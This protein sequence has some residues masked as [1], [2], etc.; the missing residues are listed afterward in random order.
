MCIKVPGVKNSPMT[1]DRKVMLLT[2]AV[3]VATTTV[4]IVGSILTATTSVTAWIQAQSGH[5]VRDVAIVLVLLTAAIVYATVMLG[6]TQEQ[7]AAS[8]ANQPLGDD[9][10]KKL[11]ARVL[12]DRVTPRLQQGLRKA[13]RIGNHL[14]IVPSAVLPKLRIYAEAESGPQL[15]QPTSDPIA[16]I[17]EQTASGRLL[18]LGDP[19]TGKTNLLLELAGD[20]IH[21]AEADP[22][23]P[24]PIIF[25]LPRW[26]LGKSVRKLEEWLVDDLISEYGISR[27]T[28]SSLVSGNRLITL[29]DGLDEVAEH[30]RDACVEA[31][32]TFQREHD[33]AQ[34]VVCCRIKEY[35]QMPSLELEAAVRIERLTRATIEAELQK[36]NMETVAL[37]LH[38]DP[39]LW[40]IIDTPLWI[41][42]LFGAAQL[43]RPIQDEVGD[44]RERLYARYIEYALSR[45]PDGYP[46]KLTDREHMLRWLGWLATAMQVRNQSQFSFEDL[47]SGWIRFEASSRWQRLLQILVYLCAFELTFGV[48]YLALWKATAIASASLWIPILAGLGV[49][50]GSI[51]TSGRRPTEGISFVWTVTWQS[52]TLNL[53]LAVF[54][55]V[56]AWY[57]FHSWRP[58]VVLFIGILITT[59]LFDCVRTKQL[60]ERSDPNSGTV[61]SFRVALSLALGSAAF[62]AIHQLLAHTNN[63]FVFT[64][65]MAVFVTAQFLAIIAFYWA[66]D[67]VI[68]N[69]T[70]RVLL[71][72]GRRLPLRAIR[73][74]NEAVA[75]LLLIQRG[76]SYEFVHPTFRDHF[77][78]MYG[79]QI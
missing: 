8:A 74:F 70:T 20:L 45:D 50:L 54:W 15:E 64:L 63:T 44:P 19:G 79:P 69:Y 68:E 13:V 36:P 73:F 33:L 10:R 28:A 25:S 60:T 51:L 7:K 3:V 52:L 42:V 24:I 76:G 66:G 49:C 1:R 31:I 12:R 18:I 29:L 55:A 6:R 39:Q 35:S 46:R 47:T 72:M 14:T 61:R 30:Q 11:L 43:A 17:F 5:F 38:D 78:E 62:A 21:A 27:A 75:R 67:F 22:T 58:V 65:N 23:R 53:G 77:A 56:L 34:I 32:N 48:L 57:R 41:H 4:G 2:A 26:T 37:A 16:T 59:M 9:F 40:A 71:W